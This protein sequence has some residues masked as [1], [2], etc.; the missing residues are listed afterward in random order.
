MNT[1]KQFLLKSGG[2]LFLF[3]F[4]NNLSKKYREMGF[5]YCFIFKETSSSNYDFI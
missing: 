1:N 2:Y 3:Y 4:L 5:L